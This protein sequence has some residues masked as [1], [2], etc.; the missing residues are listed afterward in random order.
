[1][2]RTLILANGKPP[3]KRLFRTYLSSSDIFICADGGANS[4]LRFGA[5]PH[6]IIGDLDSIQKETLRAFKNTQT[7]KLNS[8]NSTD[9]EKALAAAIRKHSTHITVLGATGRR[10]DHA[11][12]NLSAL[13]KFSPRAIITFVDETCELIPVGRS[14]NLNIPVGTTV[15]LLPISR[16]EGI[17]T[18]GLRWNLKNEPLELGIRDSTS[19]LVISP[20]ITMKVRKGDLIVCV[21]KKEI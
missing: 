10:I 14:L 4:A 11:I 5:T 16:C 21:V 3:G 8:Q 17:F 9:L 6:L 1:M 2:K 20:S 7:I 13:V 12:G 18:H 19:N 15:S